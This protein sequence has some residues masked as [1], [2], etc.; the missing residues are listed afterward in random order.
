MSKTQS[1]TDTLVAE[2]QKARTKSFAAAGDGVGLDAGD[3]EAPL[4]GGY[5]RNR[6]R[7]DQL[8]VL[9]Q[10]NSELRQVLY[11]AAQLQRKLCAPRE[12]RRGRFEIASEIF[13][14]RHLSGD[15]YSIME[16]EE[17]LGLAVGDIAGK[18]LI[19]G[20]WFTYLLGLVRLH[21]GSRR[22]PAA[23][24]S[25]INSNLLQIGSEPPSSALFLASLNTLTGELVY[26]NAGQPPAILLRKN[27]DVEYLHEGGPILGAIPGAPFANGCLKLQ[28]GDTFIAYSDGIVECRNEH[29]EEF[30]TRRLLDAALETQGASSN[31]TLFSILGGTQDFAS[32]FSQN[33]DLTLMVVRQKEGLTSR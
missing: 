2:K 9:H 10:E 3:F 20:L 8:A 4:A 1:R 29:D 14:A 13:P 17:I 33:D 6:A 28:P 32:G 26:C 18:G 30:G 21:M 16:M 24:A 15:F 31:A 11:G 25:A 12:F 23:C 27:R 19:A 7:E 22:D 5:M